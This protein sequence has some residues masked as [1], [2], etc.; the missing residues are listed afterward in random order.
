MKKPYASDWEKINDETEYSAELD[1]YW[2]K[3]RL[4]DELSA[5]HNGII[6]FGKVFKELV[7]NVRS[8]NDD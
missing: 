5:R 2:R 7:K 1:R 8:S 4:Y 3:G 6:S